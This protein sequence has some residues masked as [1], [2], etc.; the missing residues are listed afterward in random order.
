MVLSSQQSDTIISNNLSEKPLK[1]ALKLLGT[2]KH[3]S[4]QA[5][6]QMVEDGMGNGHSPELCEEGVGGTY[7]LLNQFGERIIVFKPQDEEPYNLNNPKGYRPRS[8]S[9]ASCKEGILIGEASVRECAAYLLDHSHFCRVPPTDLAF[10]EHPAFY[11]TDTGMDANNT[12]INAKNEGKKKLGSFQ[13][14]KKHDGN[15]EDIS[16]TLMKKFPV[17]EVHRIALLDLRLFNTDRH[18]GNILYKVKKDDE[19]CLKYALIPIDHGYTLPSTLDEAWFVWHYWPQAKVRMSAPI[20]NY[21]RELDAEKDIQLL[22]E[23][24]PGS[25]REEH[26]HILRLSTMLLKKGEAADLTFFEMGNIMCRTDLTIPSVLEGICQQAEK[27]LQG[28]SDNQLFLENISNLL[29]W[30]I[31]KIKYLKDH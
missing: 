30:E 22:K 17:E 26:F 14:F 29:D 13:K 27:R 21:I 4:L 12:E 9:L 1:S 16:S 8:G 20:R 7:F 31:Q 11:L 23:K 19:G 15:T 10:C 18:G 28:I 5:L 25:F 6:V 3:H 2:S 24:F